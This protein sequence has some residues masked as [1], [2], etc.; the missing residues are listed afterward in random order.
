[1]NLKEVELEWEVFEN[2]VET[3]LLKLEVEFI[4]LCVEFGI[5]VRLPRVAGYEWANAVGPE[6]IPRK[7]EIAAAAKANLKLKS[8]VIC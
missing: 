4:E 8:G 7:N 1:M 2:Q 3:H 5:R 6:R